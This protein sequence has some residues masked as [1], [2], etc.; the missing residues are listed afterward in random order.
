MT[1][2]NFRKVGLF[3]GI[4][5]VILRIKRVDIPIQAIIVEG[6]PHFNLDDDIP[7]SR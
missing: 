3:E 1:V 5:D 2:Y 4:I 7:F 6:C